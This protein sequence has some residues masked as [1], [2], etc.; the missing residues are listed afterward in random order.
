M[1]LGPGRGLNAADP[2]AA[3]LFAATV[4]VFAD[5]APRIVALAELADAVP[6]ALDARLAP[7]GFGA[8]EH[9][10]VAQGFA[11]RTVFPVLGRETPELGTDEPTAAGIGQRHA[12]LAAILDDILPE[13]FAGAERRRVSHVAGE[14]RL[15]QGA[16]D[17]V[18]LFGVP[19]F[20]HVTM[21]YAS[22][23]AGG[24]DVGKAR[25]DG[26]HGYPQGFS[27]VG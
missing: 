17:Y 4:P 10:V 20:F 15:D 13:D 14:A 11:L 2:D 3:D 27:F 18:R 26:L 12:E 19:N 8:G 25:F 24:V 1:D 5:Y 6:G 23:R 22:L 21:G 16:A 9:L 7:D